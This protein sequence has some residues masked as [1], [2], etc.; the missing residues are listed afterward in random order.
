MA[1]DM[2]GKETID[3]LLLRISKQ[4]GSNY[5]SL[6]VHLKITSAEMENI[7]ASNPHDAEQWSFRTLKTWQ[8]RQAD[9]NLQNMKTQLAEA[10]I[11]AG[12]RDIAVTV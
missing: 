6:S 9:Q 11:R 2:A 1:A 12:R 4:V 5:H 10:L 8:Q 3:E 7:K